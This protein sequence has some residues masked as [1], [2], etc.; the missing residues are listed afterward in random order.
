MNFNDQRSCEQRYLN[1]VHVL[2]DSRRPAEVTYLQYIAL[3]ETSLPKSTGLSSF[4]L[5]K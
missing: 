3:S 5:L 2:R 4:F 1:V